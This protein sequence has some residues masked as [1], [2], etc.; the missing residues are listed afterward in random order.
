MTQPEEASAAQAEEFTSA[1]EAKLFELMDR[2]LESLHKGDVG[3]R[4]DVFEKHP[5]LSGWLRRLE[6]VDRLAPP[7]TAAWTPENPDVTAVPQ[8]FGKY[9]L[10]GEVGR[11]GMG[12]VY[13][14][15]TDLDRTVALKMILSNRLASEDDVRRFQAEALCR[16]ELAA[17]EHRGDPRSR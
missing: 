11:G 8:P 12:V 15:Q 7:Q 4:S 14:R 1:E 16:R 3:S 9:E 17:S 5:E 13:R 2:Y 10:L 6:L